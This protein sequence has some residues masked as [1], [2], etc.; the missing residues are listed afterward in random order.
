MD[1]LRKKLSAPGL[2][3]TVRMSFSSIVDPRREG[4][5]IPG[6]PEK[7]NSTMDVVG[8]SAYSRYIISFPTLYENNGNFP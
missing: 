1:Q 6:D 2:L 5:P 8:E 7:G 3:G 4:S